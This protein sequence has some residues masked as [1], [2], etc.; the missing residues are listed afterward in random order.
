MATRMLRASCSQYAFKMPENR[1][2][3]MLHF[4]NNCCHMWMEKVRRCMVQKGQTPSAPSHSCTRLAAARLASF[5][6][7]LGSSSSP[8]TRWL[9]GASQRNREISHRGTRKKSQHISCFFLLLIPFWWA[10][11]C[12]GLTATFLKG[13]PTSLQI[14]TWSNDSEVVIM[15][16]SIREWL[17]WKS[18][19]GSFPLNINISIYFILW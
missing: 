13:R 14:L 11:Q 2:K 7:L 5:G 6:W 4:T 12:P 18:D 3:N 8:R 19:D 1:E 17:E 16:S 10:H 15:V 9:H